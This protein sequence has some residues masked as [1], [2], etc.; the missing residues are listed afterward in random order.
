MGDK[1]G[2]QNKVNIAFTKDLIGDVYI[3]VFGI[4]SF[5]WFHVH[6]LPL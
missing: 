1:P 5:Y 6:H 3:A 4:T 2:Y